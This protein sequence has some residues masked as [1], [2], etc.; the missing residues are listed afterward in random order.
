MLRNYTETCILGKRGIKMNTSM[1]C[2]FDLIFKTNPRTKLK[3]RHVT[4]TQETD[5]GPDLRLTCFG[6]EVAVPGAG[7]SSSMVTGPSF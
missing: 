5:P 1:K 2:F 3:S 6:S 7:D 4:D